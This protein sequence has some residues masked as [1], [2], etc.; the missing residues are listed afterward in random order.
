MSDE[1]FRALIVALLSTGGATF[2]WTLFKS[3]IAYKNSAEG[4]E[5]KAV[6]RLER[7][8][9]DCRSQLTHERKWSAYWSRRA[10]IY[11]RIIL[12]KLGAEHLPT[13]EPDPGPLDVGDETK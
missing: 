7:F 10:A 5:D 9:S 3:V 8:E 2:I 12:V 13:P 11:E 6:G 4:R 1:T